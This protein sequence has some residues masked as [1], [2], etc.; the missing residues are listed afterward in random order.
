[1][2]NYKSKRWE[3]QK[4]YPS[5][6]RYEQNRPIVWFRVPEE[7]KEWLDTLRK[8]R[9]NTYADI[10]TEVLDVKEKE[11]IVITKQRENHFARN[12]IKGVKTWKSYTQ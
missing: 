2:I 1:M 7:F 10:I 5:Q 4:R 11:A 6:I 8:A 12:T 3:R 9:T